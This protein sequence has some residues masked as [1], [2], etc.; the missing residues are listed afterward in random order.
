VLRAVDPDD[1]RAHEFDPETFEP[2]TLDG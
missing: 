2:G 1:L